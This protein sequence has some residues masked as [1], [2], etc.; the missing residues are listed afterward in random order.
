MLQLFKLVD[1]GVP[2]PFRGVR[3]RRSIVFTRNAADAV[4]A[5]IRMRSLEREVFFVGDAKALS[6][7]D[8]VRKI[9]EALGR[10]A[11]LFHLSQAVLTAVGKF[12][13]FADH[14]LPFPLTSENLERL[15]G[16]L[17]C[18]TSKLE[19][20][21]GYRPRWSTDEALAIT[22]DWYDRAR[23]QPKRS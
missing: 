11:R 15:T 19:R 16:S 23:R 21:T 14:L 4:L 13:D 3:N 1:H 20:V 18:T 8:L 12:G 2:L 17:E 7:E 10:P 9:A 22:A 5:L 6:T